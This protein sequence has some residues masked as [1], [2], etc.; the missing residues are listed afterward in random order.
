[1]P[2]KLVDIRAAA[3][4]IR[5]QVQVTPCTRSL[6]LSRL[7][8]AEVYLK[9]ENLQFTAAF[10]ERGAL[11]KLLSLTPAQRQ[12]GVITMSAGNHAQAVAYHAQR[13]GIP[14]TIVMP[15]YTPNVKVEHTRAFGA[16][17]ILHG[18][19]F[20]EAA[21][22]AKQVTADRGLYLVHPYDDEKVIAGQGTMALEMLDDVPEL[23]VFVVP[24]GGGGL[25]A[26]NAVAAKGVRPS[27]E[28]VGVQ[29][30]RFPSMRQA[31]AGEPIRCGTSTIAEGIAVKEPGQITRK[32]VRRLVD[33]ILLVGET[34]I[35]EAVL[36]LLEVEKSVVEGAGA[37]GL[38]ALLKYRHHFADKKV[39]LILSGGNIDMMTLS[40]IIQRGLVRTGRLARLRVGLRD[41][42]GALAE[43]TRLISEASANIVQVHHH[44]AF[45][46]L[47]LQVADVEFVLQTR[48][49]QH[50]RQ[51][52]EALQQAG[53]HV[54][55]PE[56]P[57]K[58]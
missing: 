53:Y 36:L 10:K 7:T 56:N 6:T 54:E 31:L 1:M 3:E 26:G 5:G 24:V 41:V 44:R 50:V 35:E 19:D 21:A 43:I 13:L 32:I 52:V 39:G 23:E 37:A 18:D 11:Y 49:P 48:G 12:T 34:D 29:T 45:T 51:I 30:E 46:N 40:S 9:F 58:G 27:I 15:R 33:E 25:I 4:A 16:D 8:G 42:P 55:R 2:V 22:Y 57:V 20:D 28:I 14:A 17:V 47:P 38:A